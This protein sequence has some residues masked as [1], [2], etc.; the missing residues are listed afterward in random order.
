[1]NPSGTNRIV[2]LVI[3]QRYGVFIAPPM[4]EPKALEIIKRWSSPVDKGGFAKGTILY[5]VVRNIPGVD[6]I[7]YAVNLDDVMLMHT[8]VPK[9][10]P[11]G[12]GQ[13]NQVGTFLPPGASGI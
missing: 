12:A 5:D 7:T 9:V 3:R 1:M 13:L 8:E 4:P 11:V 2:L 6:D 10:Q